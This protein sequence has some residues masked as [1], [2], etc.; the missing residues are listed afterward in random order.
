MSFECSV[1]SSMIDCIKGL[2]VILFFFYIG[3]CNTALLHEVTNFITQLKMQQEARNKAKT[4]TQQ[5]PDPPEPDPEACP[6]DPKAH[7]PHQE[8]A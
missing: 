8:D 3:K 6:P 1:K 7:S 4:L 5:P 2:T